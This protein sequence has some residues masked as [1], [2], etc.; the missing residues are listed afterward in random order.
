MPHWA[1]VFVNLDALL[2]DGRDTP[3]GLRM[4]RHGR[5]FVGLYNGGGFAVTGSDARLIKRVDVPGP[6]HANLAISPDGKFVYGTTA[7]DDPN[8]SWRGELYRAPNPVV[9]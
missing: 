8:G 4:D 1:T 2:G 6:H 5:L 3:D 9:E 7:Y